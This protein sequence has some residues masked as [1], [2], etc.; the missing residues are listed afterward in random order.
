MGSS[1]LEGRN[2]LHI[3]DSSGVFLLLPRRVL[4]TRSLSMAV[5]SAKNSRRLVGTDP[6]GPRREPATRS[7]L[8]SYKGCSRCG[9][10]QSW[11]RWVAS[12][13]TMHSDWTVMR[14]P[15][16]SPHCTAEDGI[17]SRVPESPARSST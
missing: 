16:Y 12:L 13:T 1:G 11:L 8:S 6:T 2:Y 10:N 15:T 17:L 9:T 5:N 7:R 4:S 14:E 3:W